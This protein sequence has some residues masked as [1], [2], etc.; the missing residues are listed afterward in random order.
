MDVCNWV[1]SMLGV[2][3]VSV[4]ARTARAALHYARRCS[5]VA[6]VGCSGDA[7]DDPM[8]HQSQGA[9]PLLWRDSYPGGDCGAAA[10]QDPPSV[11]DDSADLSD[12]T[13]TVVDDD[14]VIEYAL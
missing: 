6:R 2:V 5:A 3:T 8:H 10:P 14:D 12:V 11:E 4:I 9:M 1:F 7:A 13:K